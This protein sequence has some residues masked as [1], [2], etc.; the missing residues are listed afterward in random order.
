MEKPLHFEM[1]ESEGRIIVIPAEGILHSIIPVI[2][3]YLGNKFIGGI[4]YH[5]KEYYPPELEAYIE[6]DDY[7]RI[8]T[9]I[10]E[11][12]KSFWPWAF[13][14]CLGYF[15]CPFTLGLSLLMPK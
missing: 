7:Q 6:F 2:S 14:I 9:D 3:W 15:L 12:V 4:S 11:T 1:P 10:N 8:F 13:T 5:Y